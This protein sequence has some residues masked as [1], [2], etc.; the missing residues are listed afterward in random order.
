M[1]HEDIIEGEIAQELLEKFEAEQELAQQAIE[2][3]HDCGYTVGNE[4]GCT[5]Q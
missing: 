5:C 1:T 2:D 4:E 3:E